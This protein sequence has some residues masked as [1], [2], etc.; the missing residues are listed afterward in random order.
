MQMQLIRNATVKYQYGGHKFITDPYLAA[1]HSRPSFT[2]KSL[3][4]LTDLPCSPQEAISGME[5]AIISHLHSDHFDPL[6]Q[7]LLPKDTAMICQPEDAEP[8]R[9]MGFREVLPIQERMEWRGITILRTSGQHG[10][11][12][13]LS[14]MGTVS[15]FIFKAKGEPLV[16]W[17]GDTIW[18]EPVAQVIKEVKPEVILTHSCGAVWGKQVLI[19]MDAAQT[20]AV[21]R[22]APQSKVAA[23]HMEA[24]DHATVTRAELR[25]YAEAQGIGPEQMLIPADGEKVFF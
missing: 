11:G 24:L 21:C 14:D 10:S 7:E 3:N 8:I 5:M 18:C 9:K 4:P 1:K 2:G 17:T 22:A 23:I 25:R 20:V 6:A 15:G 13:V 12:E 19:V 16:Y